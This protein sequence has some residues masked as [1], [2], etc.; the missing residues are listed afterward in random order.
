MRKAIEDILDVEGYDDGSYG[1]LLVRT[2]GDG[3]GDMDWEWGGGTGA[4]FRRTLVTQFIP[5]CVTDPPCMA[6]RRHLRQGLQDR[7]L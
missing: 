3:K 2:M 5:P 4:R 1:P 6:R 7:G